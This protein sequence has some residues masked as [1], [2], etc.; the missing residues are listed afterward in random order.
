MKS[1]KR[2]IMVG[3]ERKKGKVYLEKGG[4]RKLKDPEMERKLLVWYQNHHEINR[5]IVT[6][7]LMR[8]KALELTKCKDFI[9]S[10]GWLNKFKRQ[11]NIKLIRE[12][13]IPSK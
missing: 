8:Q 6:A 3:T 10:K 4:G 2:W 13:D 12:S 7:K 1:L 11:Y 9:A 5:N